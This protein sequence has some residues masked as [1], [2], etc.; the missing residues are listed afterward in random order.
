M[1]I[2]DAGRWFIWR[3]FT[4]LFR[5][6]LAA[7]KKKMSDEHDAIYDII[8]QIAERKSGG[9]DTTRPTRR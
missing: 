6:C 8:N 1:K 3:A 2:S 9:A 5:G 4:R 7:M